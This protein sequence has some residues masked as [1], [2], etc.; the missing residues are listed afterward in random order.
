[1]TGQ[2]GGRVTAMFRSIILLAETA[3]QPLLTAPLKRHNP[4]LA[5]VPVTTA[6]E[7]DALSLE[8]LAEA[9]L[10]AFTTPII[11]PQG[12]LGALG[13]DAYNFHPGPPHYPGWCPLRFALYEGATVFGATFHRMVAEVDAGPI[14][15]V[16]LFDVPLLA[17]AKKLS[18]LTS[19]AVARLY[20]RQAPVLATREKPLPE[21]PTAWGQRKTT[22]RAFAELCDIPLDIAPEE[23]ERRVVAFGTGDGLS[24]PTVRLHGYHFRL[25]V[26]GG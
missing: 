1:M 12:V 7:L 14:V 3:L 23:L 15:D 21:L 6:E 10:V 19:G 5:V 16:E 26:D 24:A 2:H 17:S 13:Y 4:A 8:L 11:V 20:A 22:R 25:V 18:K 9:R